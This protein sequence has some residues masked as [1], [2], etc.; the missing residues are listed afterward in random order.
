METVTHAQLYK[1]SGIDL[2]NLLK[3]CFNTNLQQT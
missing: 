1:F 2:I 3:D